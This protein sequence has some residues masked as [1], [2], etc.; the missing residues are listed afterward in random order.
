MNIWKLL[1]KVGAGALG[2]GGLILAGKAGF[3]ESLKFGSSDEELPPVEAPDDDFCED[4]TECGVTVDTPVDI[5]ADLE[6][7]SDE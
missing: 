3:G 5:T 6:E 2:L 4:C 1:G 7:V